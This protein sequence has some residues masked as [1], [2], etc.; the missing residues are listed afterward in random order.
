MFLMMMTSNIIAPNMQRYRRIVRVIFFA[1]V[2]TS[3]VC[4]Q[5]IEAP[6]PRESSVR[7]GA[8]LRIKSEE[9]VSLPFWDDFSTI[10]PGYP[11]TLWVNSNTVYISNGVGVD[12]PS[13]NVAVF[14]GLDS[15]GSPYNPNE[16]SATGFTDKLV[17]RPIKMSEV[18]PAERESVYLSFYYQWRGHGEP[19]DNVDYLR[20]EFLTASGNW[21]EAFTIYGDEVPDLNAFNNLSLP[22][23]GEEYFHDGFRFRLRAHGRM[24]GPFDTWVVDYIYLNKG[25]DA[26]TPSFP[27]RAAAS[28]MSSLFGPYY[29]V[30][31]SHFLLGNEL[32]SVTFDVQNLRGSDFGG[33]SINYRVNAKFYQ[34]KGEDPPVV[35]GKNLIKSRGVKG[36]SGVM[37]PYERVTVRLDTLPDPSDPLQFDPDADAIDVQLKLKVISSDSIDA[38]RPAFL[39]LDFRVNDT[40]SA[41]YSLR[42]YYA[43]DDGVAEYSVGLTQAGNR[44]AY[45]FKMLSDT[46][47]LAGFEIYFPY[48][49]GSSSQ[50]LDLYIYDD[51]EGKP[52]LTPVYS[53]LGR[54]ITKNT[55]NEFLYIPLQPAWFVDD[56]VFYIGYREPVSS[57]IKIGLDK[58]NDTGDRIFVYTGSTWQQNNDIQGSLMIR[59]V[60]GGVADP[61][62]GIPDKERIR[63][64]YPNPN[65]GVFYIAGEV[66]QLE[67]TDVT[68]RPAQWTSEAG[69]EEQKIT[70]H[71]PAP[72]LYI[73][74]WTAIDG[75]RQRKVV[76]K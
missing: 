51:D 23:T 10:P 32:D 35:Y 3:P 19:P 55:R 70:I 68:G 48:L 38:E 53:I 1:T 12:P 30:P 16:P 63:E 31:L 8:N 49:G 65:Q 47:S 74:K 61:I 76:V 7:A 72:G 22:V 50:S 46:A 28:A 42:D 69:D 26:S 37:L 17:S 33:A 52:G 71:S 25:R 59:P 5:L 18:P 75:V 27:D 34:Y 54:T 14:D 64:I 45:R 56:S 4:A 57:G 20:V 21:V 24:S 67:I 13:L 29:A 66:A 15:L 62:T 60:F 41:W 44:L 73:V 9:P 36:E 2:I 39:P 6:L 43:Y 58:S 40:T 11:D